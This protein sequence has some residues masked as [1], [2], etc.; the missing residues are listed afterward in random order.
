MASHLKNGKLIDE[1]IATSD[2]N[3][4]IKEEILTNPES[5]ST[6]QKNGLLKESGNPILY[7]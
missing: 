2:L 4:D 1:D 6:R 5:Q 7:I 3:A